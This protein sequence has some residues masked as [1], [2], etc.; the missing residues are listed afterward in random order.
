MIVVVTMMIVIATVTYVPFD[1]STTE[2]RQL[3]AIFLLVL[4]EDCSGANGLLYSLCPRGIRAV[5]YRD[6][7]EKSQHGIM[8]NV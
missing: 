4:I 3:H 2:R 5:Y 6:F 1:D 7:V 8:L